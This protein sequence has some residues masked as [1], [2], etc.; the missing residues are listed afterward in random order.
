MWK[1]HMYVESE[2]EPSTSTF[3]NEEEVDEFIRKQEDQVARLRPAL[4]KDVFLSNAICVEVIDKYFKRIVRSGDYYTFAKAQHMIKKC[5]FHFRKEMKLIRALALTNQHR[6]I[7]KTKLLLKDED[8]LEYNQMLIELDKLGINPVTIPQA[9]RIE[10]IPNLLNAYY[11][12][13]AEVQ[14]DK[15]QH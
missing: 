5:R 14:N 8:L 12:K 7:H 1:N 9:W 4:P 3:S 13:C 6:G 15:L 2:P 11:D 10:K